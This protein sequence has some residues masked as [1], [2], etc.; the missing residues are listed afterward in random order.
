M[1][2]Y[3][4]DSKGK[5]LFSFFRHDYKESEDGTFIDG[6]FD[7]TR[8]NSQI[9]EDTVENLIGEI[10][11]IFMWGSRFDKHGSLLESVKYQYLKDLTTD[12]II[13]ILMYFTNNLIEEQTI[14]K[15]WKAIH[16]IFLHE[17]KYRHEKDI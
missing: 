16:L 6:G 7:Y 9:F 3:V 17:L 8:T 13:N 1:I 10:R 11:E 5:K 12:H 2:K 15:S 14:T 4:K